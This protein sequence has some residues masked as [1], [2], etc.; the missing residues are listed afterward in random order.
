MA[1]TT[2]IAAAL[3]THGHSRTKTLGPALPESLGNHWESLGNRSHSFGSSLFSRPDLDTT[4]IQDESEA[5]AAQL[6]CRSAP[7]DHVS[8]VSGVWQVVVVADRDS[9]L[10]VPCT[11]ALQLVT[12]TWSQRLD[13]VALV[14]IRLRDS[15]AESRSGRFQMRMAPRTARGI[16]GSFLCGATIT[17]RG[18]LRNPYRRLPKIGSRGEIGPKEIIHDFSCESGGF[19]CRG[20]NPTRPGTP[21][22]TAAHRSTPANAT[23]ILEAKS[24]HDG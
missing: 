5:V 2:N 3:R 19:W 10:A 17:R 23:G 24:Q 11:F 22:H 7:G 1:T 6:I 14:V 9:R 4:S 8:R 16:R 20:D 15:S 12:G 21:R 13:I 18:C